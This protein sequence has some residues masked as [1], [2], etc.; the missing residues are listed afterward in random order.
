MFLVDDILLAPARGLLWIFKEIQHAVEAE[1][2][3]EAEAI[4]TKLSD[5]YMMLETG[6][7]TEAEFDAAEKV[8]LDRLDVIKERGGDGQEDDDDDE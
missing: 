5:L 2:A 4:T 7:M 8:L 3:N 6:Q 1:Q